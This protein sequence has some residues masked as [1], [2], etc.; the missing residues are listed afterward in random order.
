MLRA[1]AVPLLIPHLDEHS[2]LR[3]LYE[4][5]DGL[6]LPGGIDIDPAFYGESRHENLGRVDP[7]Q[8]ET[9]LALA[10]W[11]MEE[12]KPFLAICRG[13]QVLNVALGGSLFQDIQTQ[14]PGAEKH[15][16]HPGFPRNQMAHTATILPQT[17]LAQILGTTSLPVNSMH[18]QALKNVAP[19]LK[20]VARAPDEIIEAVEAT[21]H[22]FAVGV[23]W[24]PEELIDTDSRAGHLFDA[25]VEACQR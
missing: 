24:H 21:E 10:R 23:Q 17:C 22:T 13:I 3:V 7:E 16:W 4:K 19:G 9:E 14:I 12:G 6:L 25:L 1:G 18:H 2:L 11:A 20:V 5:V 8:D 15:D